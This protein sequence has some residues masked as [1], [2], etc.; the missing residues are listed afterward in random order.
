MPLKCWVHINPE[1]LPEDY[2]S[3]AEIVDRETARIDEL[4]AKKE[5]LIELLEDQLATMISSVCQTGLG[6]RNG[7]RSTRLPFV[8]TIPSHW[9]LK[10]LRHIS[11]RQSVGLVINPS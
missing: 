8:P 5:R 6:R 3:G 7:F 2:D 11:P 1:V 10:R 4:I 9:K